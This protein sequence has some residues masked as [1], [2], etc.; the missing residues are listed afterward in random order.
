MGELQKIRDMAKKLIAKSEAKENEFNEIFLNLDNLEDINIE[1]EKKKG[2]KG[3]KMGESIQ[4]SVLENE[5]HWTEE[6]NNK[7][8]SQDKEVSKVTSVLAALK[9]AAENGQSN[10]VAESLKETISNYKKMEQED[11]EERKQEKIRQKEEERQRIE[12]EI[13]KKK[14][15]DNEE[16]KKKELEERKKKELEEKKRKDL[17]ERN[18][19]EIEERNKK[20]LE[21][22][23]KKEI[24][25]EKQQ[26]EKEKQNL[27][28]MKKEAEIE[29]GKENFRKKA[30]EDE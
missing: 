24:Q 13:K 19:K 23:K 4:K 20:E 18:M 30:K 21:E 11:E 27:E 17:E 16:K 12:E 6:E 10:F 26:Q 29:L 28:G 5:L 9:A 25:I 22:R 3:R 7:W 15:Q 8:Q 2:K 14:S 1:G